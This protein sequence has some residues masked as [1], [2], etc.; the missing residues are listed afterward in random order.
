[1]LDNVKIRSSGFYNPWLHHYG[2][3]TVTVPAPDIYN[4]LERGVVDVRRGRASE[5]PDY[6]FE[7]FIGYRIDPPVWQFDNLIWVNQD[8]WNSLTD[9]Q[10]AALAG[11]VEAMSRLPTRTTKC[12]QRRS[13]PRLRHRES[14]HS[15]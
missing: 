4:A 3:T 9:D 12:W 8:R 6:G 5:L 1:M 11:A 15:R 13:A 2:A 14:S 7:K 10:R